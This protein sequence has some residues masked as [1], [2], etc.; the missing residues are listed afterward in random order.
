MLIATPP[1]RRS[2]SASLA[3]LDELREELGAAS[4]RPGRWAGTLRRFARAR[5]AEGSISI[6][7]FHVPEDEAVAIVN[8][9]EPIDPEDENRMA[10]ACYARAMDHVG[11]MAADPSF[12]WSD[13]AV[14]DLHFDICSFQRDKDPG[15]WR[16]GPVRI[17]NGD[18]ST[19]YEGPDAAAVPAL[20]DE[21]VDWLEGGDPEAHVVVRAAM[22]HLHVISI[23]PF[24]DG[25]GRASRIVQSL[26]L[27]RDG[28][29]SPELASIE[30]HLAENTSAYYAALQAAHGE[31][32]E[33]AESDAAGWVE[34]CVEAHLEQA[35]RR[36]AQIERAAA[37]WER[38]EALIEER[39][40]PD[41]LMLALEQS[42][43]GGADRASYCAEADISAPTASADFRRLLDAGLVVQLGRGRATRYEADE[44][45]RTLA[46]GR[47][48]SG[49]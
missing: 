6:E 8:R 7:G 44:R 2:L 33:P 3:E 10:L 9:Q 22:A 34:F 18:G 5:S 21:A 37:R 47:R 32:Y 29:L 43:I 40:W 41:R 23:H 46:S 30:E 14:L 35:R 36:L 24:L 42:L 13:R 1:A 38:L 25:N 39:G 20:M 49:P 4:G 48:D 19:A 26:V 31:R 11:V 28:L 27:A 45:L 12:R 15:R 17:V 16:A